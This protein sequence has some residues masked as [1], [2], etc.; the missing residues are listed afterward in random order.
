MKSRGRKKRRKR[1]NKTAAAQRALATR[2]AGG[3]TLSLLVGHGVS[4]PNTGTEA[5]RRSRPTD[6]E[7]AHA[8][9]LFADPDEAAGELGGRAA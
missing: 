1:A 6:A 7:L 5:G 3:I 4:Q 8:A 9:R 2:A